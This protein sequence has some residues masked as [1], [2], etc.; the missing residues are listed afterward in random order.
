MNEF[1]KIKDRLHDADTLKNSNKIY[2][3][4]TASESCDKHG[5]EFSTYDRFISLSLDMN[6][7]SWKGY[8]GDSS[9]STIFSFKDPQMVKEAFKKYLNIKRN[10][11]LT[12]MGDYIYNIT[13]NDKTKAEDELK[14]SLSFLENLKQGETSK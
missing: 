14:E 2:A 13:I 10:E 7:I 1:Q 11:I 3:E 4:K 6:L 12:W 8:Y 9:C 5:F